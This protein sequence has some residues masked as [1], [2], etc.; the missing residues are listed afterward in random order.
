MLRARESI[1]NKSKYVAIWL[2][3]PNIKVILIGIDNSIKLTIACRI[4][5]LMKFFGE[6][7]C[8]QI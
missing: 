1:T 3:K 8:I 6:Y 5:S 4:L 7:L 2:G